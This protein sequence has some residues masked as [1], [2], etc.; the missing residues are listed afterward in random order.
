MKQ[1]F[2][3]VLL[4]ACAVTASAQAERLL[5]LPDGG[6]LR[7]SGDWVILTESGT[8]EN[9][10]LKMESDSRELIIWIYFTP[11]DVLRRAGVSD[12]LEF[13][14]YD[15]SLYEASKTQPF[16]P[17]RAILQRIGRVS[18]VEYTFQHPDPDFP[19]DI[20]LLYRL[21]PAGDGISIDA[22]SYY[23][24]E[25]G[26]ISSLYAMLVSYEPPGATL[27]ETACEVR[28]PGGVVLRAAP[29]IDAAAVRTTARPSGET[30]VAALIRVDSA[31]AEWYRV[32]APAEA[33]V[34]AIIAEPRSEG[35]V[36]LPRTR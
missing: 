17:D 32:D 28:V 27:A 23:D 30:L 10:R 14:E 34:R 15:Y 35:C 6:T 24:L 7:Y 1:C 20:T 4:L 9:N 8:F 26:D 25:V 5:Q 21:T 31:G 29:S 36:L 11:R 33:Y 13:A 18:I 16:N 3:W 19:F 22:T 2:G 12:L